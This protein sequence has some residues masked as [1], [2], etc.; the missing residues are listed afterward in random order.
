MTS[1]V[2]KNYTVL[3]DVIDTSPATI[4]DSLVEAQHMC[5]D[6][7]EREGFQ[8]LMQSLPF[9]PRDAL[10]WFELLSMYPE[11]AR[12]VEVI[13]QM[14][15]A[16]PAASIH[17]G[18]SVERYALL[19]AFSVGATKIGT[20]PVAC[21]VKRRFAL[22]CKEI[23]EKQRQ[24]DPFYDESSVHFYEGA[25]LAALQRYPAGSAVFGFYP[26]LPYSW[27]L[28]VRPTQ[29]P[30]LVRQIAIAMGGVGPYVSPHINNGRPSKI[31]LTKSQTLRS[32]WRIAKTLEMNP[33][34]KGL[35]CMSWFFSAATGRVFPHLAWLRSM[36]IDEGAYVVELWPERD[37]A[38][39]AVGSD[40][41]KKLYEDGKFNPRR[42]L[43]IWP[44]Y[45]I[46]AW[47]S[48]HLEFADCDDEPIAAPTQESY[49]RSVPSP[50]PLC[51]AKHN[52]SIHLW[53]GLKLL[54]CSPKRYIFQVLLLPSFTAAVVAIIAIAWWTSIPAFLFVFVAAWLLQYYCFQ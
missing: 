53:D 46:L 22:T 47:A 52:S 49:V 26:R 3:P 8:R 19:Q 37:V 28:K 20:K 33:Q 2:P 39:L 25:Q 35:C 6:A 27:A 24:W 4:K 15:A 34:I 45:E 38:S 36:Y 17:A 16:L 30:G 43:V 29:L 51:C 14:K 54:N 23:A 10:G 41:R 5:R 9:A 11:Q 7:I 31:I 18:A 13:R 1:T 40:L 32:I 42:S 50:P 21:S 44:R 48:R 12:S